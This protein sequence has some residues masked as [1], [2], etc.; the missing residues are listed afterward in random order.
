MTT[1]PI[2][3]P[4]DRVDGRLKV[5]GAAPYAADNAPHGLAY[6]YLV[7]STIARGVIASMDTTAAAKAPGV[8]AVYTP[9]NPLKL[10]RYAQNQNDEQTP[11][12]QDTGVR[13]HGQTIGLVIAE[14]FEQARDAAAMVTT[15]YEAQPPAVANAIGI[16]RL[17]ARSRA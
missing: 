4:V 17:R 16:A 10:F 11:P 13:Y 15:T 6:G 2:G 8:V 5:T 3:A 1:S 14:T 7:T 12:L 9:F